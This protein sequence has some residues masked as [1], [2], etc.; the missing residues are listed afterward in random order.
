[1]T[2]IDRTANSK[3]V[4]SRLSDFKHR[5]NAPIEISEDKTVP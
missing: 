2:T 5:D 4:K 1:M 3:E